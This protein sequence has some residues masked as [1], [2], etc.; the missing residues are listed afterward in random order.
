MRAYLVLSCLLLTIVGLANSQSG[1]GYGYGS[2]CMDPGCSQCNDKT[3]SE[4]NPKCPYGCIYYYGGY[5]LYQSFGCQTP[6]CMTQA[7]CIPCVAQ[8]KLST[9]MTMVP[10]YR[11]QTRYYLG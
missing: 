7:M 6:S 5:R 11:Y 4:M 3:L 9:N 8:C 2:Y 10:V 1:Y